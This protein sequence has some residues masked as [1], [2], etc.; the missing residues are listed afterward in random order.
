MK[1]IKNI[2][3]VC[4]NLLLI[5][6]GSVLCAVAIK[7]ILIP[8]QFLAGGLTGLSLLV[9]SGVDLFSVEHTVVCHWMEIY[10]AAVL[11]LQYSRRINLF[12]S[13][14]LSVSGYSHS[15]HDSQCDYCRPCHRRRVRYYPQIPGI[16]RRPGYTDDFS[17]QKVF[18]SAGHVRFSL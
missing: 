16:C 7:G 14:L 12:I 11:S 4:V 1:D 9:L 15:G 3:T 5:F 8:K 17:L 18:N 13:Y 6:A 2:R 10:R